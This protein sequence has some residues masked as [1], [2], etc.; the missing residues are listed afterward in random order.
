MSTDIP[1]NMPRPATRVRRVSSMRAVIN[2]KPE[3]STM[4]AA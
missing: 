1:A 3:T 2:F 4:M